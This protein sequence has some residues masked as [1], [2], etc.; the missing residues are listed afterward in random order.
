VKENK[1]AHFI[2]S[3]MKKSKMGLGKEKYEKYEAGSSWGLEDAGYYFKTLLSLQ[4]R[5]QLKKWV[6]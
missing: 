1:T 2:Q 6:S 4:M 3:W 5:S